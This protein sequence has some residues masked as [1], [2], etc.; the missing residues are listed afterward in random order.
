MTDALSVEHLDVTFH[1]H[2]TEHR[3]IRDVSFAVA[4]GRTT[5][6]VGESGSGKTLAALAVIGLLP[7]GARASGKVIV[8]DQSVLE[9]DD[10][11]RRALRGRRIGFVF[12]DA[13]SALNP[14]APVGQLVSAPL[15]AHLGLSRRKARLR[16]LQVLAQVGLPGAE[17]LWNEYPHKLSE[18]S[19]QRVHLAMA[20]SCAPELVILDEPTKALDFA[21]R[22]QIVQLLRRL[23][24]DAQLGV[25]LI[26]HD[27]ELVSESADSVVIMYAGQ[28][29]E[30][31]PAD[32]L[33]SSPV[34]P[35][36]RGLLA[37]RIPVQLD[38]PPEARRLP[39]IP[40][41]LERDRAET[42]CRFHRRC[43]YRQTSPP[44]VERCE[45]EE[46]EL[47]AVAGSH[48]A[49]CHFAKELS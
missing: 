40:G 1:H 33:L 2:T 31:G 15:R 6:I 4:L 29:V 13:R 10:T 34:H 28:V 30:S 9:L 36:S 23:Q 49:R 45:R 18:G 17:E 43:A 20:L 7:E 5:A 46:P 39:T 24:N 44:G 11:A 19:C 12:E 16:G 22:S 48:A 3:V 21:G 27:L 38:G 47:I 25:L 35:Y 32:V 14:F 26:A 37:S 41:S 42:G 8:D